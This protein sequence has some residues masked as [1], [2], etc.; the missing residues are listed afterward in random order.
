MMEMVAGPDA[1]TAVGLAVTWIG[2][3]S[4]TA[5]VLGR[6]VS[7]SVM[8]PKKAR[9]RYRGNSDVRSRNGASAVEWYKTPTW[10]FIIFGKSSQSG[11]SISEFTKQ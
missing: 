8:Y 3:E 7:I 1:E 5:A 10:L 9:Q 2:N 4:M 11:L 6:D